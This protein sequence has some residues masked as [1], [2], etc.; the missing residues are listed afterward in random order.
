MKAIKYTVKVD[1]NGDKAWWVNDIKLTQK[2]FNKRSKPS[3]AGKIV[4]IDGV[5]YKLVEA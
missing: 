3:C 1:T 5:K 2:D 4:E